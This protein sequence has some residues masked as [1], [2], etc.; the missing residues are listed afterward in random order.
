MTTNERERAFDRMSVMANKASPEQRR[1]ILEALRVRAGFVHLVL[2]G[3]AACRQSIEWLSNTGTHDF[4]LHWW[5]WL[6]AAVEGTGLIE[7]AIVDIDDVPPILREALLREASTLCVW[8]V[9]LELIPWYYPLS[10]L[11][12]ACREWVVRND[13]ARRR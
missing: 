1:W 6:A 12:W 4:E 8:D 13:A 7:R 10:L 3:Q 5:R 11:A 2:N 9:R